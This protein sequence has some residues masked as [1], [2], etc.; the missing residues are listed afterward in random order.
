[1]DSRTHKQSHV[2]REVTMEGRKDGKEVRKQSSQGVHH[3]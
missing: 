3:V 2:D 1:M